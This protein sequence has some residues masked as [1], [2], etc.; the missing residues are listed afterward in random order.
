MSGSSPPPD[1]S[2]QVEQMRQNA[3][4]EERERVAQEQAK[5]KADLASL[6]GTVRSGAGGDVRNYFSSMGIDPDRYSGSIDSQLNS[7]LSGISPEDENPGS[8]FQGAGQTIYDTLQTG[9]RTKYGNQLNE[10]FAPEWE[11]RR[12]GMTTDDPYLAGIEGEQYSDADKIIKNMLDRGVLTTGG[13]ASAQKDL[14]GQRAGVRSRLNEIGTGLLTKEQQ[15][16]RDI[17]NR[18]RQSASTMQL[19]SSFDPTST[20][21]SRRWAI[22]LGLKSPDN[23]LILLDLQQSAALVRDSAI[24]HSIR[25]RLVGTP[26]TRL[27]RMTMTPRMQTLFSSVCVRHTE[28]RR[29]EWK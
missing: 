16:L 19:G 15:D 29:L 17:S 2:L 5:K 3:A 11:M 26:R 27:L 4:K 8:A 22:R 13:Y 28:N 24:R 14:E 10:I 1:N 20:T 18:A 12:V 7:I 23:S 6:R 25:V 21:S 9:E